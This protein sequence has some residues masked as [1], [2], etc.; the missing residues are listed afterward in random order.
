MSEQLLLR[1]MTHPSLSCP[2]LEGW[3][4]KRFSPAEGL[5]RHQRLASADSH[6]LRKKEIQLSL[7]EIQ[8]FLEFHVFCHVAVNCRCASRHY[9]TT[10][11][12]AA[13]TQNNR[14]SAEPHTG[15]SVWQHTEHLLI[16]APGNK[17]LISLLLF[18]P[19]PPHFGPRTLSWPSVHWVVNIFRPCGSSF[20]P[21]CPSFPAVL[22]KSDVSHTAVKLKTRPFIKVSAQRLGAAALQ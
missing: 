3:S 8:C 17:I 18:F 19:S 7:L 1:D 16:S 20:L 2:P 9:I 5:D 12:S 11:T 4:C 14:C 10:S 22:L 13:C 15:C 6:M 21:L